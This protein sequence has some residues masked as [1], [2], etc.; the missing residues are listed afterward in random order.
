MVPYKLIRKEHTLLSYWHSAKRL[1]FNE[2]KTLAES[3]ISS[4]ENFY[5]R[6]QYPT[7]KLKAESRNK[8]Q[9]LTTIPPP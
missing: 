8:S 7:R 1:A 3:L 2:E 4:E 9:T 6:D 5:N